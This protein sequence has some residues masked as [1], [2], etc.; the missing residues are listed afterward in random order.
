M[1]REIGFWQFRTH[2]LS[3]EIRVWKLAVNL[4]F[5]PREGIFVSGLDKTGLT[6][7]YL[8]QN[9]VKNDLLVAIEGGGE[10]VG[11]LTIAGGGRLSAAFRA[12]IARVAARRAR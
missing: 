8:G 2:I 11:G 9:A 6:P 3:T 4:C 12:A 7:G 1:F 5:S 10:T